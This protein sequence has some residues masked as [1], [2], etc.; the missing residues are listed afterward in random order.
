VHCGS[1]QLALCTTQLFYSLPSE[2]ELTPGYYMNNQG[3][4][5]KNTQDLA[6]GSSIFTDFD[7]NF[8]AE[9]VRAFQ[10]MHVFRAMKMVYR[11]TTIFVL[12]TERVR[13]VLQHHKNLPALSDRRSAIFSQRDRAARLKIRGS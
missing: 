4:Q 10:A 12:T 13:E 8:A 7:D 1:P 5:S 6:A 9:D 3:R 11:A 2:Y